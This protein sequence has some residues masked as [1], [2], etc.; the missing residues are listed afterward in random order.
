MNTLADRGEAH[1]AIPF[2]AEEPIGHEMTLAIG[3]VLLL[4]IAALW[5]LRKQL[6]RS[7]LGGER[8]AR[9]LE[10]HRLGPHSTLAVVEFAGQ[11]HLLAQT[12]QGVSCIAQAPAGTER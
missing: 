3:G 5:W 6:G 10:S 9:V 2:K 12:E 11:L 4:L 1:V 8:H 7:A